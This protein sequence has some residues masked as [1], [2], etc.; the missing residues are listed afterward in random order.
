MGSIKVH[1]F[2]TLDGVV[3]NPS[4][5]MEIGFDPKMGDA[6]ARLMADSTAILLGRNTYELFAP[7]WSTRTVE[8]DP[9]AP[10]FNDTMKHV[11]SSTLTT[12]D[13]SNS[14]VMGPYDPAAIR[15]LKASVDGTVYVSGS[16]TLVRAMLTDQLVDE[17]HLF[18]YPLTLGG[19]LRLFP[20]GATALKLSLPE[21]ETYSNGV[22]HLV[23]APAES[24]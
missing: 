19:G 7:V 1:E 21:F 4:W 22:V 15:R 17:L 11:V 16:A 12:T 23:Y 14:T 8:D 18:L 3:E 6:I 20:N 2:I 13:W 9:G 24:R 5:T 10:F